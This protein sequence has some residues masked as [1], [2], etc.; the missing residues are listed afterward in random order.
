MLS[1]LNIIVVSFVLL[2]SFC[3]CSKHEQQSAAAT[4]SVP[5]AS[6]TKFAVGQKAHCP[7][8]GEDFVVKTETAQVEHDGKY[9]AFC[10]PDCQPAFAKNPAKYAVKN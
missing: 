5:T 7:V 10:C 2:G 6:A 3:G 9:Y 4:S 8:S 1:R